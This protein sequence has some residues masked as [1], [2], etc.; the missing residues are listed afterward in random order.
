M[1]SKRVMALLGAVLVLGCGGRDRGPSPGVDGSV[2]RDDSGGGGSDTGTGCPS[3]V[4]GS[5]QCAESS[6]F[7]DCYQSGLACI[8]TEGDPS[9]AF[10]AMTGQSDCELGGGTWTTGTACSRTGALGG[11]KRQ[12]GSTAGCPINRTNWYYP[13][14]ANGIATAEDVMALC[15]DR[16]ADFVA[17]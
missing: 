16:G 8:D 2:T 17:P 15:S 10:V 11:C 3:A 5:C 4:A 7:D 14:S 1:E 6:F 13:D 12:S 9:V